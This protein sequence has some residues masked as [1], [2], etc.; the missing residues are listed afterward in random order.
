MELLER[1]ITAPLAKA[2]VVVN[3]PNPYDPQVKP[4]RHLYRRVFWQ[5]T[6]GLGEAFMD[7]DWSCD[8]LAEL[9]C[10]CVRAGL[11]RDR[12]GVSG[13]HDESFACS[14]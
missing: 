7:G 9:I 13:A 6:L 3:G 1:I 11:D 2:G 5:G 4:G 12:T 8:D 10:R 14:A